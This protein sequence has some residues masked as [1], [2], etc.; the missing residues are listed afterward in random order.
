[1]TDGIASAIAQARAAARLADELH[2]PIAP[3][4]LGVGLPLFDDP[5]LDGVTLRRSGV[6]EVGPATKLRFQ[7]L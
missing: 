3:V 6:R 4:L 5:D 1:M 2:V 7:V